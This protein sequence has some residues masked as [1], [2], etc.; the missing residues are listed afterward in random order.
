MADYQVGVL[1]ITSKG[2]VVLITAR[3]GD[4][5]IFP[6]GNT[7]KGRSDRAVA[8]EEAYEEAGLTGVMSES[9]VEFKTSLGKVKKL[10][11]YRMRVKNVA[12][13]YPERKERERAV[14]SLAK[15]EKLLQKDLR[16]VL[17]KAMHKRK[18]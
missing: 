12:K 13:S 8:R 7:E 1:P 4:T 17:R 15:A 14:V 9:F 6:K 16:A 11:L 2:K 18:G 3:S 5:W 10:R